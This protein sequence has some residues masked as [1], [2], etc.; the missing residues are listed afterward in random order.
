MFSTATG[1]LPAAPARRGRDWFWPAIIL[2]PGILTV[3]LILWG[4]RW[5]RSTRA[6]P[7]GPLGAVRM[8]PLTTSP[9]REQQPA[10]S[11]DGRQVAFVWTD[12]TSG[13]TG[14]YVKR[15]D[16][17]TP[18]R[19]T[20]PGWIRPGWTRDEAPEHSPAWSPDGRHIAF[21]R[22]LGPGGLPATLPEGHG[23]FIIPAL[24]G[25]ERQ[26][27]RSFGNVSSTGAMPGIAWTPNG[28]H[29]AV[30][31]MAAPG[32]PNSIFQVSLERDGRRRLTAS[33]HGV[34]DW[35]PAYSPD[36]KALAF[37]R[38]GSIAVD[39]IYLAPTGARSS[40]DSSVGQPRRITFDERS[41]RGLAWTADGRSIVFSS[42]RGG[43]D[44]H[45]LWKITATLAGAPGAGPG[46]EPPQPE[47]LTA[48][49]EPTLRAAGSN[50]FEPSIS[51][52]GSR[53]AYA[54]SFADSNIWR[55]DLPV[56]GQPPVRLIASA[57]RDSSPQYSPDGK[58]IVFASDRSGAYEI[59]A[60][61][62]D[63]GSLRQVTSFGGP[64]TGTPRWSPDSRQVVFDSRAEGH[65]DI[66]VAAAE[67]GALRR[68]T[69]EPSE[70]VAP[71]WSRDGRFIYFASNR[72]GESQVWKTPAAGGPAVQVTSR[73]GFAA[74]EAPGAP[75]ATGGAAA[76]FIYYAKGRNAAG[77]W[78]I[79][80]A[81]GQEEPVLE[82]LPAGYW[83]YWTVLDRGIY[84][85]RPEPGA[86]R[87][88]WP[89]AW[90]IK[91][92]D[93]ATRRTSHIATIEK[94]LPAG[95]AGF[96]VSPDGRLILYGQVDQSSSDIMLL[97]NFR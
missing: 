82:A 74:F 85:A 58:K 8:A 51:P 60:S 13:N 40:G 56:R 81:G 50:A 5:F 9:G 63:G 47:P 80:A 15:V 19:L 86:L 68:I 2:A 38:T 21:L 22:K 35:A 78:R 7:A 17:G 79:P 87:S 12:E 10:L 36:G 67:G 95:I 53:L 30:S 16:A 94:E 46:R 84:F 34:G 26:A 33:P 18:L 93:F 6:A 28:K 64:L 29:L 91:F 76:K 83:G 4:V 1:P 97:E 55:L 62:H 45:N 66:Y 23:V 39:D 92:F 24:G 32:E 90:A 54:E 89:P 96:S 44:S 52:R 42:N 69:T 77:I 71:S 3:V 43:S 65:A 25:T 20:N 37:V 41:V 59:W 61:A 57:R 73:G 14:I 31:D 11:P 27:G 70:D 75:G 88:G 72:S 48:G 49:P